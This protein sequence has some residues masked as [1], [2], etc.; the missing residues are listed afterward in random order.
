M[1]YVWTFSS[2]APPALRYLPVQSRFWRHPNSAPAALPSPAG[3]P[4]SSGLAYSRDVSLRRKVLRFP[5]SGHFAHYAPTVMIAVHC[6]PL[7][8]QEYVSWTV[9]RTHILWRVS[10]HLKCPGYP[11]ARSC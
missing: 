4:F 7:G 1:R 3:G 6:M 2:S 9:H 10:L 8:L 11:Q 5:L